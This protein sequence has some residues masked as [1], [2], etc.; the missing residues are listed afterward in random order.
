MN[1]HNRGRHRLPALGALLWRG[2]LSIVGQYRALLT[3]GYSVN[4]CQNYFIVLA[5]PNFVDF[6]DKRRLMRIM[7]HNVVIHFDDNPEIELINT[8]LILFSHGFC[9]SY[10]QFLKMIKHAIYKLKHTYPF[11][12]RLYVILTLPTGTLYFSSTYKEAKEKF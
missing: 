4:F 10:C 5:V 1:P 7:P 12:D 3:R 9:L 11:L 6:D 2:A 8:L